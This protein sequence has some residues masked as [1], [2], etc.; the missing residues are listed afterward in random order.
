MNKLRYALTI[1]V[2]ILGGIVIYC[3]QD[4]GNGV[5]KGI[6]LCINSV[7]PSLFLFSVFSVF[8]VNS[9]IFSNNKFIDLLTFLLCGLRGEIGAVCLL[10]VVGGYPVGGAMVNELYNRGKVSKITAKTMLNFCINPGPA[11][12]IGMV[13]CGIYNSINIGYI[14]LSA[15]LITTAISSRLNLKKINL[16]LK[17][18][19]P[20]INY[21]E[22]FLNSVK[23]SVK[24]MG[25]ICGWVILAT[26]ISE[27]FRRAGVPP[28]IGCFFEVTSGVVT[29]A[30]ISSIY[31]VAFLIGFGGLSVHL[32]AIS[33][34]NSISPRYS[35]ILKWKLFQGL[36]TSGFTCALLKIFPQTI[37]V[38]KNAVGFSG[39]GAN[40]NLFSVIVTITFIMC[41]LIYINQ[42]VNNCR[43]IRKYVIQ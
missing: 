16:S 23:I 11:F 35:D 3:A 4:I 39:S 32:Q 25:I 24:N 30:D 31:F 18:C 9:E 15:S 13:G 36:M 22:A 10:S 43:K 17:P 27:V 37:C 42:N 14:I 2:I 1:A 34:A 21:I 12:I 5:R 28:I 26:A 33:S 20:N 6:E 29:A 41:T 19:K 7:I 8:I 38:S 40:G